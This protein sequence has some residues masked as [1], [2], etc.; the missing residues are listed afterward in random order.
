MPAFLDTIREYYRRIDA[1]DLDWVL[2]IFAEDAVYDR[3][4]ATYRGID[5]VSEFFRVTRRI[6]G[7][8]EIDRVWSVDPWTVVATGQ[9]A[10]TGVA[11]DVRAVRFVDIWHFDAGTHVDRRQTY[12]ALGHEYVEA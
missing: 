1:D 2:S 10:G 5:A 9:F 12:L 11:G 4:D 8:H 3:A 7:I 6:S